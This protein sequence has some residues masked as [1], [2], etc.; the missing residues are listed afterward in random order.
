M[1]RDGLVTAAEA[2]SLLLATS[3]PAQQPD[4]PNAVLLD[5]LEGMPEPAIE[6]K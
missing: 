4:F 2:Q 1:S 5:E 3:P 6:V